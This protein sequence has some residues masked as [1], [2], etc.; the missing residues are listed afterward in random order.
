YN[1]GFFPPNA[2]HSEGHQDG[3]G[4]CLYFALAKR[5]MGNDFTFCLLDDVLV[6]VDINH[7]REFCRFLKSEFPHTQF[8]ITTHDEI[9]AKNLNTEGVVKSSKQ[10]LH[11]RKWTV[12]D[13]PLVWDAKEVWDEIDNLLTNNQ[14]TEAAHNLRRYLEYILGELAYKLRVK[15]EARASTSYDL[16]EILPAVVAQYKEYLRKAK[17]TANSWNQ[18]DQVHKL[19]ELDKTFGEIYKR[20]NAEQ[21][22]INPLVHYNAWANFT[23]ND[24]NP[25][26]NEFSNLLKQLRCESCNNWIYASPIKG[27]VELIRCDCG[28]VN[29]NLKKKH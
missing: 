12:N 25:V 13:G 23:K 3:M 6:S 24:F 4:L 10:M 26:K 14:M 19:E 22:S 7:R 8:V 27:V 16:G 18:R 28:N 29:L 1:R 17:E 9:W 15:L 2:L 20:T 21:W 11:F 5:L